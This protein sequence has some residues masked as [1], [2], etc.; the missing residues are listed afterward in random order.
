MNE[1]R[2]NSKPGRPCKLDYDVLPIIIDCVEKGVSFNHTADYIG[3]DITT[4]D[5][6]RRQGREDAEKGED[7]I[8]SQ[9]TQ[10]IK[11]AR[12]KMIMDRL[13]NIKRA[14]PMNWTASAWLLERLEPDTFGRRDKH[15]ISNENGKPFLMGHGKIENI[16][17]E[18]LSNDDLNALLQQIQKKLLESKKEK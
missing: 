17:P 13:K 7:T 12:V 6:W 9:L 8:F 3:V 11:K 15:E 5:A 4:L 16:K 2:K 10:A 18:E 1:K 14:E